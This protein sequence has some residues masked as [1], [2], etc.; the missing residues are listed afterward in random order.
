MKYHTMAAGCQRGTDNIDVLKVV[1][2]S[3]KW[4][5]RYH[6]NYAPV[7]DHSVQLAVFVQTSLVTEDGIQC[8][9][10]I[11]KPFPFI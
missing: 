2:F 4:Q 8:L 9:L 11:K 7:M 1:G 10:N 3:L 5:T 6:G